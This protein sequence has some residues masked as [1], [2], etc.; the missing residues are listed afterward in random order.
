[1][2]QTPLSE[3]LAA[4]A[5]FLVGDGTLQET[6]QR[7]SELTVEAVPPADLV[8][9]TLLI[10]S[11]QR[12]AVFTD[13]AAPAVDQAQYDSGEGPCVAA[14]EDQE[15]HSIEAT[16]QPGA[17]PAFRRACEDHG[18]GSVLSL[19]L[20]A[21][22]RPLGAMNLYSRIER[23]F[24]EADQATA[25]QFAA[26]AAI[27]LANT[28]AY[29]EA[30]DL[31]DRLGEMMRSRGIIEQAKGM[32]MAAQHCDEE[33]AFQVLVRASQRENVKVRDIAQRMIGHAVH[34]EQA[35]KESGSG[36]EGNQ[37]YG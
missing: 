22:K 19:P 21:D 18:I 12:T 27:V 26:Q 9:L 37:C 17:W 11:R 35:H 7:V 23:A 28:Q 25:E 13:A 4:L 30:R 33:E 32:L 29:W 14:F 34:G 36:G 5:R 6:L 8:G 20:A 15:V 2:S 24:S 31:S 16:S 3:S 1:M 10:E